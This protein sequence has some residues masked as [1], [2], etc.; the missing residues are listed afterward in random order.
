SGQFGNE[1]FMN[2]QRQDRL[3]SNRIKAV[4]YDNR[5]TS[6]N[7][8]GTIPAAAQISSG[9]DAERYLFSSAQVFNGSFFKIRQMQLGYTVP[10]NITR[11]FFVQ[12]LRAYVSLDDFFTISSYPGIDP[13][14]SAG[15]GSSQ[16]LDMGG[17]PVTKKVSVGF[18]VTF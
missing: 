1:I 8:N 6:S 18:N 5:W 17:Y 4:F 7:H 2:L 12:N 3:T 16:G 14:I 11:K 13:E 10:Q 15:T 9:T